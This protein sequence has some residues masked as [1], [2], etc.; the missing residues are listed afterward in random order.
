MPINKEKNTKEDWYGFCYYMIYVCPSLLTLTLLFLLPA[1]C[2]L[3]LGCGVSPNL[4][5]GGEN[6]EDF[7]FIFKN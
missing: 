4:I 2:I 3:M 5:K 7:I 6:R 1:S